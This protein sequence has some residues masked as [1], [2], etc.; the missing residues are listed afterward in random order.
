MSLQ[1]KWLN[2]IINFL[3]R[4]QKHKFKSMKIILLTVTFLC[5]LCAYAHKPFNLQKGV[6][7]KSE[8]IK[9]S[10]KPIKAINADFTITVSITS[11]IGIY[12]CPNSGTF[13]SYG[14]TTVSCTLSGPTHDDTIK[15]ATECAQTLLGAT[16]DIKRALAASSC[17]VQTI[18]ELTD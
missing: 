16:I 15:S 7:F 9:K 14:G 13:I 11:Q 17:P 10:A 3:C 8:I 2:F 5:N 1:I 6:Y 12:I 18:S 4:I